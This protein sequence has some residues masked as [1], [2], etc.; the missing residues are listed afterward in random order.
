MRAGIVAICVALALALSGC[1]SVE[2]KL[3]QEG[4]GT[5]LPAGD[6]AESTRR[7]EV[8]LTYLCAQA[9][10]TKLV[11]DTPDASIACDMSRFGNA[12]W[13]A[14]VSAGFNDIDRRCD[15]YLAWL[16]SRR[17]DH[18]AILSQIHDTRTF[19][20]ALLYTTGVGAAPIAITGLA[21]GL[22]SN[23]FTNYYSR[24]LFEIEKSTVSLLVRE[25]RL[26][27]RET[28]NVRIAY[29]PDAV[30]VL[31]EYLLICTPFYIE[32]LVNQRTRDSVAGNT[33][34]DKGN[35]EQIRRSLVAGT[36]LNA[37]PK[38]PRDPLPDTPG[39][40]QT[41][42]PPK[43]IGGVTDSERA[44]SQSTGAVIQRTLCL[45][46]SSSFDDT[47]RNA[48]K[49]AKLG[50]LQSGASAVPFNNIEPQIVN[51][52]ET[53]IFTRSDQPCFDDLPKGRVNRTPFER[54]AFVD[55]AGVKA[56]QVMLGFCDARIKNNASGK[57]DQLTRDAIV[58]AKKQMSAARKA[59]L[60]DP[61]TSTVNDKSYN[62]ILRTCRQAG[63]PANNG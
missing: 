54:Y 7:L 10:G 20:E 25:K 48:I 30:H 49:Q 44:M 50:A 47:M 16:A 37:T 56:F 63:Q 51:G 4:I 22:A 36:L 41:P 5:E 53:Q 13:T 61:T 12:Q 40:P 27:Y 9:G 60:T 29:Q 3:I 34:P 59:E 32:D 43:M 45:K 55:E 31:R 26:Q 39:N 21:F 19:T 58:E 18:N 17:R 35:A 46:E 23:S 38:N 28:L 14:L 8:Y 42:K 57:F 52:V 24:L 2:E 15:S 33:P 6:M 11:S 62:N 1:L